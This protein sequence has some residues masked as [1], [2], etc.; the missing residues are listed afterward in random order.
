[1]SQQGKCV[2]CLWIVL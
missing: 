1:M 2:P